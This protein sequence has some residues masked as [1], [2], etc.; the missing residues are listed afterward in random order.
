MTS[1]KNG[2]AHEFSGVPTFNLTDRAPLVPVFDG[3]AGF[4]LGNYWETPCSG[5][6]SKDSTVMLL[7]SIKKGN[8]AKDMQKASNIPEGVEFA[9]YFNILGIVLLAEPAERFS[10]DASGEG[11]EAFGVESLREYSEYPEQAE[12]EKAATVE[13]GIEELEEPVL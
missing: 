7:F 11:P 2:T 3:R 9:I 10:E 1:N 5:D 13:S 6:V 12:A 8:L 4:Q